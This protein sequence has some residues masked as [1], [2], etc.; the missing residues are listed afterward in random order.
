MTESR[1]SSLPA[2]APFWL[3]VGMVPLVALAAWRGG[4]W[5]ALI[6]A[7]AWYLTTSL[8]GILGLNDANPDPETATEQLF[9]HRA[10]TIVW[11]PLQFEIGRAHV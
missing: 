4:W 1:P 5:W 9:W 10:V 6:P 3:S 11:F 8:D 2:A 7:Y